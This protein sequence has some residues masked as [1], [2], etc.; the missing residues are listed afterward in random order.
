MLPVFV[1]F[2]AFSEVGGYNEL[3]RKFFQSYPSEEYTA[4]DEKNQSCAKIPSLYNL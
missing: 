4:Y 2:L 1:I 3:I